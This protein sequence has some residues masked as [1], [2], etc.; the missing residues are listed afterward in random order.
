MMSSKPAGFAE[1]TQLDPISFNFAERTQ[2]D[3]PSFNFAERTQL[4]PPSFNFAERT[5]RHTVRFT[6]ACETGAQQTLVK[7][8]KKQR[9]DTE[10]R[11]VPTVAVGTS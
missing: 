3:P 1:R 9:S 11:I 8:Q 2:L 4:D 10:L 7:V 5:Q 6:R